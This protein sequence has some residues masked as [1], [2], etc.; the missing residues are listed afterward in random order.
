MEQ[1]F[2]EKVEAGF[3]AQPRRNSS[4]KAPGAVRPLL[5]P[6]GLLFT[7]SGLLFGPAMLIGLGGGAAS[8]MSQGQS[9]EDLDFASVQRANPEMERR[10]QEVIDRCWARG[11]DNPVLFIHDVGAGGLSNALPELVH[12]ADRGG[13]FELR[14][15]PNDDPG[16]TP[17]EIWCNEAQER[18]VLAIESEHLETF[19]ALCKR[20]R[21]PYA[22]I[23]ETTIIGRNV[24]IYQGTTL[25][26]LS[27]AHDE[28]GRIVNTTPRRVPRSRRENTTRTGGPRSVS[29][30]R[31]MGL[32][33]ISQRRC[34]R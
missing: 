1:A 10:C 20:E 15:V 17:M 33:F 25:G 12:D 5:A 8:S 14:E 3:E 7:V 27:F 16:M 11:G 24:K 6:L 31:S 29:T 19:T 21:C 18:Y 22:V 4:E 26:A 2:R 34:T 32:S 23:G 28:R 13:K 30:D 9:A